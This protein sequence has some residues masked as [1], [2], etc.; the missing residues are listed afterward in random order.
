M[1]GPTIKPG[2]CAMAAFRKPTWCISPRKSRAWQGR[3]ART[4]Q[5]V[6]GAA[7]ASAQVAI[8]ARAT[9]PV[10]ADDDQGSASRS[11]R[12]SERQSEP[13]GDASA[14]DLAGLPGWRD[15]G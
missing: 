12:S 10:L 13:E 8:S 7:A 6:D 9:Q 4:G 14:G 5:P 15:R 1:P 11:G 3:E 2:Y